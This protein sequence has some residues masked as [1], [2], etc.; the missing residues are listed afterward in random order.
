[1]PRRRSS[2]HEVDLTGG[3]ALVL[4]AEGA[5]LR[6]LTRQTCDFLVRLAAARRRRE[7]QCVGGGRDA[8]L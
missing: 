1:M 6:Q 7:P 8:A 3:I 5:G 2:P 4:G